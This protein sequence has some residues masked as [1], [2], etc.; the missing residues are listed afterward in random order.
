MVAK[1]EVI[2]SAH[3]C[4]PTSLDSRNPVKGNF[5]GW[6]GTGKSRVAEITLLKCTESF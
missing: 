6:L 4:S 5:K 3:N 1:P 2:Q